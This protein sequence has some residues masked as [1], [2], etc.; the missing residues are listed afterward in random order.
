MSLVMSILAFLP[1]LFLCSVRAPVSPSRPL[2]SRYRS[3]RS[4]VKSAQRHRSHAVHGEAPPFD[5]RARGGKLFSR[6]GAVVIG[7]DYRRQSMHQ[8][9][10]CAC[11]S[12]EESV[13]R[14][15]LCA[16]CRC[17]VVI[18]SRCDRGQIYCGPGCAQEA[19]RCNQR[20]ARARYQA[21][22][23]GREMHAQRSGRYRARHRRVTD[24]GSVRSATLSRRPAPAVVAAA[25]VLPPF[26]ISPLCRTSCHSCGNPVSVFLRLSHIRRPL[27]YSERFKRP[28][29]A[30]VSVS[31][32]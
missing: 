21:S 14:L 17:Q 23:R 10:A 20:K 18:C 25:A 28:A 8:N 7:Q 15:F 22:V 3:A 11:R 12:G 2:L 24:Q 4:T 31:L 29:A 32:S 26:A 16:R 5:R 19:R 13:S 1:G 27:R 30:P 6:Q 9:Y